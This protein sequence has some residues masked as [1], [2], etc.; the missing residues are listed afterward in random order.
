MDYKDLFMKW[1][2]KLAFTLISTKTITVVLT[3]YALTHNMIT[4]TQ[5]MVIATGY[6][7][8]NIFQKWLSNGKEKKGE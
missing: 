8:A 2:F 4:G 3:F 7:S 6:F 5:F 1:L